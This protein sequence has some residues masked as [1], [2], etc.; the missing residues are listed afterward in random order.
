VTETFRVRQQ[1]GESIYELLIEGK[2]VC[3]TRTCAYTVVKIIT[4]LEERRKGYG[5]KLLGHVE[6]MER[7]NG[8]KILDITDIDP[9]DVAA[10]SF[11]KKN[12]YHLAPIPGDQNFL[13]GKKKLA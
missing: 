3:T 13:Q 5:T 2:V 4:I 8:T 1:N 9:A 6:E 11:F 12:G 10:V 7:K